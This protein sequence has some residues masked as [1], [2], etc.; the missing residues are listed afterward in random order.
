MIKWTTNASS[1]ND[2]NFTQNST[3]V[4]DG[5]LMK[6]ALQEIIKPTG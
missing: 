6:Y 4:G 3:Q 2:F 5:L 1:E